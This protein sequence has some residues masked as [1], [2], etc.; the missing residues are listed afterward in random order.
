MGKVVFSS[1]T[2]QQNRIRQC[3]YYQYYSHLPWCKWKMATCPHSNCVHWFLLFCSVFFSLHGQAFSIV[4]ILD[5]LYLLQFHYRS[6][7]ESISLLQG[8]SIL[9]ICSQTREDS[10]LDFKIHFLTT[11]DQTQILRDAVTCHEN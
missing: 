3:P 5:S 4:T 10:P 7:E 9:L 2:A 8:T 1:P 11:Y 6:F